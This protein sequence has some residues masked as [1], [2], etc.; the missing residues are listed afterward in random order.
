VFDCNFRRRL[1]ESDAEARERIGAFER[2]AS[3]IAT[4]TE[5][6]ESLWGAAS[7]A[8]ISVRLSRL[9]AEYLIRGGAQGCW[10]GSGS[11]CRHIPAEP[12]IVV[13]T[14]GA[15]DAHFAGY[16]AARVSGSDRIAAGAY[17]NKAAAIIV[18][19]RGSAPKESARFPPLATRASA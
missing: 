13:D 12:V 1:W 15:G 2:L 17:A 18:G 19:Q 10:V 14:A 9:A 5:D 8:Q 7:T 6:E 4:G 3:V 11:E 16:L